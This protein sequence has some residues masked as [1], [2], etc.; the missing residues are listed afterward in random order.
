MLLR[1]ESSVVRGTGFRHAQV[2]SARDEFVVRQCEAGIF[3]QLGRADS[4][5]GNE[6]P[7][8]VVDPAQR[9]R[10]LPDVLTAALEIVAR[11]ERLQ[12][13]VHSS[14]DAIGIERDGRRGQR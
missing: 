1:T 3:A 12:S 10:Q 6:Q 8:G 7:V 2:R 5:L 13:H 9:H 11:N 14:V 4:R